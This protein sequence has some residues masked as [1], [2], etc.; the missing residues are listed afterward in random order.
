MADN[1]Q[2]QTSKRS[3]QTCIPSAIE[4]SVREVD[5]HRLYRSVKGIPQGA[6]KYTVGS[7]FFFG[8]GA[9]G[10]IS[11]IPLFQTDIG[12]VGWVKWGTLAATFVSLFI[13]WLFHHFG[14]QHNGIIKYST[15]SVEKD[16]EDVYSTFFP[17]KNLQKEAGVPSNNVSQ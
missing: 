11:L 4:M 3:V 1:E 15:E 6:S 9:S 8:I 14:S 7:S 12:I 2:F 5:W 17:E 13:G 16:M 10:F